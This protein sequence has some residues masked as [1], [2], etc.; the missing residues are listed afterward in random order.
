[1]SF[2]FVRSSEKKRIISDL[3]KNF[4]IKSLPLVL[5]ETGREKIRAFSGSMNREEIKELSQIVNV[6]IV[7]LYLLKKESNY[8]RISLDGCQILKSQIEKNIFQIDENQFFEWIRARDLNVKISRGPKIVKFN[9]DFLG[10]GYSTEDK[11]INFVPKE[12]S[13]RS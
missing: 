6:E 5:I 11:I 9:S 13:I 8:Y 10:A 7:G 1:M 4:G 12:R 3:N 2:K